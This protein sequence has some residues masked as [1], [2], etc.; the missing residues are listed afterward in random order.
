MVNTKQGERQKDG[1][2]DRQ[3]GRQERQNP[4]TG[5]LLWAQAAGT[6]SEHN[7]EKG[8]RGGWE[9]V[10]GTWSVARLGVGGP[11]SYQDP[12]ICV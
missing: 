11:W 3:T 12:I 6:L 1:Q 7:T 5:T 10:A 2:T 8:C 9:Q 4:V